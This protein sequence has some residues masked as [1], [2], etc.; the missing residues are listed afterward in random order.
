MYVYK[1]HVFLLLMFLLFCS[2]VYLRS[3]TESCRVLA[4]M[5]KKEEDRAKLLEVARSLA[6]ALAQLLKAIQ[7]KVHY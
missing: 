5:A 7:N 4:G 3:C 2:E 6:A 1:V